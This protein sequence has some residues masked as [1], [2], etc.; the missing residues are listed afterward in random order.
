M[1]KWKLLS[2][3]FYFYDKVCVQA[4]SK[5]E[6]KSMSK[7]YNIK[8]LVRRSAKTFEKKQCIVLNFF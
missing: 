1:S 4:L 6:Q 5:K 3:L 7:S 2:H 8:R